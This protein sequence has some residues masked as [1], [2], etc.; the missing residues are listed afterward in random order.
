MNVNIKHSGLVFEGSSLATKE[1][2][3]HL[4]YGGFHTLER[5]EIPEEGQREGLI[6]IINKGDSM[7][8]LIMDGS[9]VVVDVFERTI[10]SGSIYALRVPWEGSVFRECQAG[11]EGLILN[12]Y[13]RNYPVTYLEWDEFKPEMVIGKVYCSILNM[14]R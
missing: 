2:C 9:V 1:D 3:A 14:F 6:A 12:P 13:N 5:V 4:E 7:E 11:P 8:K 10:V